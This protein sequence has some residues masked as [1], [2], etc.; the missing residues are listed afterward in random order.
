M[1]PASHPMSAG[2][3]FSDKMKKYRLTTAAILTFKMC[4]DREGPDCL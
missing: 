4:D 3:A 2:L 1:D